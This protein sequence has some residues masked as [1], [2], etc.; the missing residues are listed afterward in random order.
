M[1]LMTNFSIWDRV[2]FLKDNEVWKEWIVE[3]IIVDVGK[4][5]TT[6]KYQ[7]TSNLWLFDNKKENYTLKQDELFLSKQD[8]KN[9]LDRLNTLKKEYD[10][11]FSICTTHT[12]GWYVTNSMFN[13]GKITL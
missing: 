11:K 10:E 2:F 9:E 5:N 7:I 13:Y 6:I 3:R 4:E 8:L 1:E 12:L